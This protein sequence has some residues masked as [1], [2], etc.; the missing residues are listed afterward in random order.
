MI[1]PDDEPVLLTSNEFYKWVGICIK[2]WAAIEAHLY[3]ICLLALKVD[4]TQVAIV[5]GRTPNID[6]RLTLVNELVLTILPGRDRKG[7]DHP[8]VVGWTQLV[9]DIRTLLK[10]RNLLAHAP[11]GHVWHTE[12]LTGED[13]QEE[14]VETHWLHVTSSTVDQLRGRQIES[15]DQPELP[16]HF[17]E[18]RSAAARLVEFVARLKKMRRAKRP[19]RKSQ[20]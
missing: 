19:P 13:G 11:V 12:W 14:T 18:V 5:Y 8:E 17:K 9:K 6:A 7:R 20:R 16:D 3:D 2:E 10:I 15:I 1:N 4:R